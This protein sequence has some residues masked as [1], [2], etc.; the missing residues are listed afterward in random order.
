MQKYQITLSNLALQGMS[1]IFEQLIFEITK[2]GK[3]AEV[4]KLRSCLF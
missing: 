2:T 4:Q 3:E 1:M